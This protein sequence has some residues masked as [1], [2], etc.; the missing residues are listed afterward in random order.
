MP[1]CQSGATGTP[2]HCQ[3]QTTSNQTRRVGTARASVRQ[4][5]TEPSPTRNG[6]NHPMSSPS[7]IR[8]IQGLRSA[9]D[10]R[11]AG[12]EER[13]TA[14]ARAAGY[15]ISGDGRIGEADLASLLGITPRTLANKRGAG[16]APSSFRVAG[17]GH[18]VTYRIRDVATWI[19]EQRQS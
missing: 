10:G 2:E 6:T 4:I 9:I 12:T 14:S 5:P 8:A 13:L 15:W 17:G 16:D 1:L 3:Q 19:E 11:V 18:R 7:R